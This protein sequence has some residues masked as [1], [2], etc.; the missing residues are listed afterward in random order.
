MSNLY[1]GPSNDAS[2][3]V[4]I[5]LAKRFQRRR[6]LRSQPIRN[7][8]CLWWPCLLTDR[9]EMSSLY[10][11]DA[12]DASYQVC[13]FAVWVGNKKYSDQ[14]ICPNMKLNWSHENFKVLGIDFSLD[15][16]CITDIN[17]TKKIKEVK[18]I[19]KSWQH[20][21]LTL[22]GKISYKKSCTTK[23][24]SFTDIFTKFTSDK[25]K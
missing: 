9:D 10:R 25:D 4:S 16:N 21:K 15:L 2:Y 24:N 5:H 1:R 23:A 19:L 13:S 22:L 7:K 11:G 18:A 14:I 20:R 12:I 6:F 8:N 17:F 3:Q